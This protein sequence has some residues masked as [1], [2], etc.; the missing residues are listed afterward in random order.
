MKKNSAQPERTSPPGW[1]KR[2][3]SVCVAMWL[4][5]AGV[6]TA[7]AVHTAG[8]PPKEKALFQWIFGAA[9][10]ALVCAIA[11]KNPKRTHHSK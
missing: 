11:F 4:A 5:C 2:A 6:P 10:I 1:F 8:D 7:W 3:S 9:M